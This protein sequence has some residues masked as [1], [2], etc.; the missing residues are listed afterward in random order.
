VSDLLSLR[1]SQRK[2]NA[3]LLGAL[4]SVA[5][6]LAAIGVYGTVSYWVKQRTP[7]FGIRMALGADQKDIL[8][9]VV[10]GGMQ[11]ILAGLAIGM[12]GALAVT[13]LIASLLFGVT[14]YDPATFVAIAALLSLVALAAC[15]IPARRAMRVDPIVALRYE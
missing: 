6:L 5:L 10:S 8:R 11:F 9:L 7:E 1:E 13:R 15:W 3:L 12:A 14:S 2:F 4:A